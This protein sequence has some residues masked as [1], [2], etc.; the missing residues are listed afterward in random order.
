MDKKNEKLVPIFEGG[1]MEAEIIHA[2]LDEKGIEAYVEG[3]VVTSVM[4]SL[5]APTD[6]VTVEVL[7][8][9]V[10]L[11]KKC[12]EDALARA[13]EEVDEDDEAGEDEEVEDV[14]EEEEEEEPGKK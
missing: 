6:S 8:E 14:Y 10:E 12:V 4:H 13:E 2:L 11:A 3:E 1:V 7:E 5:V 9:N